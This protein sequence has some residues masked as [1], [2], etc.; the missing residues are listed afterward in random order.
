VLDTTDITIIRQRRR[1][2]SLSI[3]N[4]ALVLKVPLLS[5]QSTIG[6]FVNKHA[7]WIQESLGLLKQ[8]HL[9]SSKHISVAN[10]DNNILFFGDIYSVSFHES[11]QNRVSCNRDDHSISIHYQNNKHLHKHI[12]S[13]FHKELLCYL[14]KQVNK[15]ARQLNKPVQD[16]GVK[17]YK[18]RWGSCSHQGKLQFNASLVHFPKAIIDYVVIHE[19]CHLVHFDHSS[20][21]WALV[22]RFCPDY[23]RAK[24]YLKKHQCFIS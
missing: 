22:Q 15:Y 1:S 7:Q 11:K 16:I 10:G 6:H 20:A 2:L 8:Q 12:S 13:F 24:A 21:F 9:F 14:E 4:Q 23:K 3:K 19:C 5:S 18:A 17:A